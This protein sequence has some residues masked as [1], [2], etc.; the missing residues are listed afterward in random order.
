MLINEVETEHSQASRKILSYSW[1]ACTQ[2][3][4][5]VEWGKNPPFS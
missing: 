1:E 4:I 2:F 3:S 5:L